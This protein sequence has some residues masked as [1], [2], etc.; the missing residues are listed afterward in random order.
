LGGKIHRILPPKFVYTA[1]GLG[2]ELSFFI[3]GGW[4]AVP[5]AARILRLLDCA[6]G[7]T[8]FPRILF[9]CEIGPEQ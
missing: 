1:S 9:V 6:D 5:S 3:G 2:A 8:S 4:G 7:E